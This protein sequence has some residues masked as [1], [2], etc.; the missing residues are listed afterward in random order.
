MIDRGENILIPDEKAVGE[1][2]MGLPA[3]TKMIL[4]VGSGT[5]NDMANICLQE[6]VFLI[7][8]YVQLH[9]W[10]DM[11]LLVLL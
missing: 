10:T 1:M 9:L 8:L 6:L 3:D 7:Q 2:F 11:L 5:L 4:S